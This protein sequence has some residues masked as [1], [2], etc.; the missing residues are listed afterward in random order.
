MRVFRYNNEYGGEKN[1]MGLYEQKDE[2]FGIWESSRFTHGLPPYPAMMVPQ[3]ARVFIQL[4][5][6]NSKSI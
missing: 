2:N 6:K 1:Q 3:G 5:G 4:Y